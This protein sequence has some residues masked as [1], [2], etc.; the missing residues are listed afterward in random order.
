MVDTKSAA[1][2]PRFD[3][4][5]VLTKKASSIKLASLASGVAVPAPLQ[6]AAPTRCGPLAGGTAHPHSLAFKEQEV[7]AKR[8]AA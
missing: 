1:R 6:Q 5:W 2:E 8:P 3:W 4:I 7:M